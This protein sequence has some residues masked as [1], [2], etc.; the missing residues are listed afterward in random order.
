MTLFWGLLVFWGGVL[1]GAS[2]MAWA[3]RWVRERELLSYVEPPARMTAPPV[4]YWVVRRSPTHPADY[5]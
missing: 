1:V 5:N 3:A 2:V 4:P